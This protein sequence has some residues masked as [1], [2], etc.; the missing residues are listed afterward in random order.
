MIQVSG[1][2]TRSFTVPAEL[3]TAFAYYSDLGRILTYLPHISLVHAFSAD[4]FRVLYSTTELGI[5][6]IRIFCDLQA[7]I[8][9]RQRSLILQPMT[10]VPQIRPAAGVKSATTHGYYRSKSVFR[11]TGS[12]TS[13]EYSLEL[14][15]ALPTPF[16][17]RLA[18][19]HVVN[20]IAHDITVRRT[21]EIADGF[22]ARSIDAYPSWLAEMGQ[23]RLPSL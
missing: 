8:D 3:P 1:S 11:N 13:I 23:R 14:E 20:R 18:P 7:S 6:H 19:G 21:R 5:Y 9:E 15:A 22:I 10:D 4:Q 2:E 12:A 17:L 16:G